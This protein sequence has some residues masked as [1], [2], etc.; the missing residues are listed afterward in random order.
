MRSTGLLSRDETSSLVYDKLMSNVFVF[1]VE[2]TEP[3]S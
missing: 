2:L 3:R 1:F